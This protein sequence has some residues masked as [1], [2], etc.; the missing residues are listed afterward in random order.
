MKIVSLCRQV[1]EIVDLVLI[2]SVNPG[3]GGQKF[4][5]SQI[6]K[7]RRLK[8]LCDSKVCLHSLTS[9]VDQW[10]IN[11]RVKPA[12]YWRDPAEAETAA[13]GMTLREAHALQQHFW[14]LSLYVFT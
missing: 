3:F 13:L 10:W 12:L 1:I 2:M 4:I 7:I 5:N 6:D 14:M 8:A 9:M 11:I